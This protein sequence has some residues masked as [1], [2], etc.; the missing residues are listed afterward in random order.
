VL[1]VIATIA[2]LWLGTATRPTPEEEQAR[3]DDFFSDLGK[4]FLFEEK[5]ERPLSPFRIIGFML[6]AFGLA[7]AAIAVFVLLFH[8]DPRAF[9]IDLL[10]AGVLI[11][12]GALMRFKA[13]AIRFRR[14]S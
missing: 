10:V 9:R 14:P 5:A 7:I 2:G 13:S 11:I 12:L 3:R 1:S 6:L 4:P 8:K